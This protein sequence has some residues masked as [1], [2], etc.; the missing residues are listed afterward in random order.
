L[1]AISPLRQGGVCQGRF[2]DYERLLRDLGAPRRL[3]THGALVCE[4]AD[5]ILAV[6]RRLNAPLDE[7]WVRA[8]AW[9]HDAGKTIH[10]GELSQP[11]HEHERAGEK[12]LSS[13][14]VDARIAQCC[15]S[16]ANWTPE[17][18]L[19]ELL[20]ALADKLWKGVRHEALEALVC[21]V[22]S[23]KLERERWSVFVE[24]DACFERVADAGDERLRRSRMTNAGDL[25]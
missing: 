14:G 20:V 1:P 23:R 10:T 8:G 5:E 25:G 3:V 11:G 16:H 22:V 13:R 21:D 7:E 18:A 19:E 17:S 2:V 9:L 15:V 12:L 6:M 24:L 4:A